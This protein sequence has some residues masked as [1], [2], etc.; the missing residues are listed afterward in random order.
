MQ[1]M[2]N[3]ASDGDLAYGTIPGLYFDPNDSFEY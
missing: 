3:V 1:G 2:D